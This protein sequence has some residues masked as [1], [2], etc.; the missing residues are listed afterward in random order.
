[1]KLARLVLVAVVAFTANSSFAADTFQ[2]SARLFA[3][4]VWPSTAELN[5]E[6]RNQGLKEYTAFGKVGVEMTVPFSIFDVGLN[7]ATRYLE[8]DELVSDPNTS[9]HAAFNQNMF[10]LVARLPFLKTDYI[11]MDVF[12]GVGGSNTSLSVYTASQ[13]GELSRKESNDWFASLYSSYGAS[14]GVGYKNFYI[15]VEGGYDSNKIDGFK[16][17]GTIN[18][19]IQTI[20]LS[21]MYGT[22]GIMFDGV[23]ARKQ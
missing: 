14:V 12:A 7:Y 20:D 13:N 11:R 15:Y 19:N 2:A 21:G 6:M 10:Q 1:M 9:Y 3:S 17:T 18:N 4:L 23:T 8:Q 16:R 22:L 5:A